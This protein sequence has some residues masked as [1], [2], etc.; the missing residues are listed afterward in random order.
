MRLLAEH[1]A[2]EG[3]LIEAGDVFYGPADPPLNFFR[4]AYSSI[5]EGRIGEGWRG[6][7]PLSRTFAAGPGE[8]DA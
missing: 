1:A 8:A 5:P 4:L 7:P 3:V 6:L 2:A